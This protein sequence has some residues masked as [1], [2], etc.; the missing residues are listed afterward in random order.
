MQIVFST[1]ET[2]CTELQNR[3]SENNKKNT[4]SVSSG[5]FAQRVVKVE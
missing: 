2:I 4:I 1:T 5:E 3:F